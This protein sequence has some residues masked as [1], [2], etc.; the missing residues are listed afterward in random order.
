M[1]NVSFGRSRL[2]SLWTFNSCLRSFAVHQDFACV[3]IIMWKGDSRTTTAIYTL[4]SFAC[5]IL[6]KIVQRPG[7]ISVFLLFCIIQSINYYYFY[8]NYILHI[9]IQWQSPFRQSFQ[10][11]KGQLNDLVLVLFSLIR[12]LLLLIQDQKHKDILKSSLRY[13]RRGSFEETSNFFF[14]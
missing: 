4:T 13:F 14:Y 1:V 7:F 2:K 5:S 12:G 8:P 11:N 3:P 6:S 9:I 10:A